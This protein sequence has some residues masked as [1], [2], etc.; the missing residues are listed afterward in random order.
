M[1]KDYQQ[2][3][4]AA[5]EAKL[6]ELDGM[7]YGAATGRRYEMAA[8]G[9]DGIVLTPAELRENKRILLT[10]VAERLGLHFF[11]QSST[12]LL[13]QLATVSALKDHD[14]A[15]LLKSLINSFLIA[16]TNRETSDEAYRCLLFLEM[17]RSSIENTD[18]GKTKH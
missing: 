16:Y 14:T 18:L 1:Q 7:A 13:D 6:Q 8:K 15:G 9:P 12:V 3:I 2:E 5:V 11:Q 10:D 4:E 17:L